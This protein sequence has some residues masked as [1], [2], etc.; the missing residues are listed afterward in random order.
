MTSMIHALQ[1]PRPTLPSRAAEETAGALLHSDLVAFLLVDSG[2]IIASSPSLRELLGVTAPGQHLD[3]RSL[4]SIV[5]EHDRATVRDFT[6]G[7]LRSDAPAQLRCHLQCADQRLVPVQLHGRS[8]HHGE[9]RQIVLVIDDLTAWVGGDAAAATL[10]AFDPV[11]GFANLA[12]LL[13][14][15]RMALAAARRYRRRSALLFIEM[16]RLDLLLASVSAEAAV[17]V[18]C[19]IAEMLRNIVR[20]CDTVARLGL[21]HFAILLPEIS[22]RDDA[23]LTAARVVEAIGRL[24]A[25]NDTQR[26]VSAAIGVVVYPTD[27]TQPERLLAAAQDASARA[28][29]VPGGAFAVAEATAAEVAAIQPLEFRSDYLTGV[30]QIDEE[31]RAVVERTNALIRDVRAGKP[32]APIAA[33]LR[34]LAQ[35]L[36]RHFEAEARMH[37]ASPFEASSEVH[38]RN[39]RFLDELNCI[40]EHSTAQSV[41]LAV[42][43]LYDWLIPHLMNLDS[44]MA[45]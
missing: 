10:N 4:A 40:L 11:T 14:R 25:G 22:Q 37:G 33:E 17:E 5:A 39:L 42:R 41:A 13:D 9:R 35:E 27:G 6:S 29:A 8:V 30:D 23:G 7:L 20:D 18:Q 43:R 31:H 16:E 19:A 1:A 24:F 21:Q 2:N 15:L 34:A 12:L 32:A 45:G 3:G 28:R 38:A 36:R 26:R 44:R